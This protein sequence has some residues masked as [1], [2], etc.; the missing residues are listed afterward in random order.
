MNITIFY[1]SGTGN[2]WWASEQIKQYFENRSINMYSVENPELDDKDF[3]EKLLEETDN[4]IL[5]YPIYASRMPEPMH[6]FVEKLPVFKTKK[7]LSIFCTQAF[8][9]G[10]GAGYDYKRVRSKGL[11]LMQTIHLNMGNNFYIPHLPILPLKGEEHLNSLNSKAAEKIKSLCSSIEKNEISYVKLNPLGIGLGKLQRAFYNTTIKTVGKSLS[12]EN[13]KCSRCR[14]CVNNCPA[15]NIKIS[16]DGIS[17]SDKCI[18]CVRCYHFCPESCILLGEK[19][20][21]K[22]KFYRYQGPVKLDLKT[23]KE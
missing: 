18:A 8:A 7:K 3:L 22:E 10:D 9:S 5:G 12:V 20:R 21:N 4:I 2:T 14:K 1:F 15:E 16:P 6:N 13:E 19:T 17:F 23:I 11:D